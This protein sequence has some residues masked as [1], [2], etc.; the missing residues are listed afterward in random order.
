MSTAPGQK[1]KL[2]NLL[3]HQL[4]DDIKP[5]YSIEVVFSISPKTMTKC[6]AIVVFRLNQVDMDLGKKLKGD[7][8][9]DFL[10]QKQKALQ[11][12]QNEVNKMTDVMYQDP[13]YFKETEGRWMA[14]ALERAMRLFD[15][16]NGNADITIKCAKLKISQKVPRRKIV[17]GRADPRALFSTA[18]DIDRLLNKKYKFDPWTNT[19]RRGRIGPTDK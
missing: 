1:A 11:E 17:V 7:H 9:P 12:I 8:S 2:I 15:Q 3:D 16:L 18:W 10:A 5:L 6:G 13:I 19:V 14:W 4:A